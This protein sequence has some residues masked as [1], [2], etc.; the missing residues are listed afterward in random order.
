MTSTNGTGNWVFLSDRGQDEYINMFASGCQTPVTSDAQFVYESST[1]PIVMRGILKYKIMRRCWED[2]RTFYYM[3]TGYFGNQPYFKNPHG[4]KL[5]HRIVPNNL[6]HSTI[7]ARPA[8]RW[9][10]LKIS[11]H[12]RQ[13]S[14]NKIIVAAPDEKPCKA[15]GIELEQWIDQT[16]STLKQHT[17]REIQV[18]RRTKSRKERT[19]KSTLQQA[20]AGAHALVTFNSNAATE[21]V[22]LGYPVF[23]SAPCHAAD[24]VA[25]RDLSQIEQPYYPSSDKLHAWLCH[26][27]YGQFHIDELANGSARRILEE[28]Q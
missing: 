1:D 10:Q 17:D 14:G 26:L 15:Y 9:E 3:D 4:W 11:L 16:V 25:N 13:P 23:V 22:M 8:D 19:T 24:P 28:T 21:A 27:A 2:N 20:L 18:R 5:H 7:I 12:R 6:Q